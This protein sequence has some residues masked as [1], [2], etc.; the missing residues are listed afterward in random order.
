M[1]EMLKV[2]AYMANVG[3]R[4]IIDSII[5]GGGV[6]IDVGAK[7]P[8]LTCGQLKIALGKT[9]FCQDTRVSVIKSKGTLLARLILPTKSHF[10]FLPP[11]FILY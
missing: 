11:Y 5:L 6:R 9:S 8:R 1:T 4:G 10:Y 2:L 3:K 7:S